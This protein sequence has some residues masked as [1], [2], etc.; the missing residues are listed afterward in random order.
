MNVYV[1]LLSLQCVLRKTAGGT[2]S[3]FAHISHTAGASGDNECHLLIEYNYTRWLITAVIVVIIIQIIIILYFQTEA[4]ATRDIANHI[5]LYYMQPLI[6]T[7]MFTD[8]VYV[9]TYT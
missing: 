5:L 1:K 2:I 4:Y 6:S 9:Y 8:N 3:F 7:E